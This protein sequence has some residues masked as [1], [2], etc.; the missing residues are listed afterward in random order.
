[1]FEQAV[2]RA[3]STPV[4]QVVAGVFADMLGGGAAGD[5]QLGLDDDFFALGGNSL[6]ATQVSA[7]L[8]AALDTAVPVRLLFEA[9]TVAALAARV[10]R[11]TG[12]GG[13][14]ALV[15]GPRPERIPLSLAQQRMWFLNRFD[16]SSPVYDI[17]RN[18]SCRIRGV[19]PAIAC[20]ARAMWCAGSPSPG[21]GRAMQRS[22]RWTGS[23]ISPGVRTSR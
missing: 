22:A 21:S 1:M 10:E 9:S 18:G 7:R 8:G 20:I 11:H 12:G 23:W 4:E 5:R 6:L 3:P 15:A 14:P 17:R 2:F 13:R 19:S 16:P